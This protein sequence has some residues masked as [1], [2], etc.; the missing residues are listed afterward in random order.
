MYDYIPNRDEVIKK[1]KE[2]YFKLFQEASKTTIKRVWGSILE[3][4]K[5]SNEIE[6]NSI[7]KHRYI[8]NYSWSNITSWIKIFDN[9]LKAENKENII[10]SNLILP[11]NQE[12]YTECFSFL[13]E[14]LFGSYFRWWDFIPNNDN[15]KRYFRSKIKE[16]HSNINFLLENIHMKSAD[17]KRF[18]HE[19]LQYLKEELKKKEESKTWDYYV[20]FYSENAIDINV[21]RKYP[22][23]IA[24]SIN[25]TLAKIKTLI[26][27]NELSS[28]EKFLRQISF[29]HIF[30]FTVS[31]TKSFKDIYWDAVSIEKKYSNENKLHLAKYL[32]SKI[33]EGVK[34][35]LPLL[36]LR[37][38]GEEILRNKQSKGEDWITNINKKEEIEYRRILLYAYFL[39]CIKIPTFNPDSVFRVKLVCSIHQRRLQ[40][41][42]HF[43]VCPC[44][45][46][47]D[48]ETMTLLMERK[49]LR[50]NLV[51]IEK[52]KWFESSG[53]QGN[54]K[55]KYERKEEL[56]KA[57]AKTSYDNQ[58]WMDLELSWGIKKNQIEE[59]NQIL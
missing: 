21:L 20:G 26:K 13:A 45:Y 35:L 52:G 41:F 50:S 44:L 58:F 12:L 37:Y 14:H 54:L 24:Y 17:S 46:W 6:D 55:L 25:S 59:G 39:G 18:T 10:S 5:S 11:V 53:K 9:H 4:V 31:D 2:K 40:R 42:N 23:E 57:L 32:K 36:I 19:A 43:D 16:R 3:L 33:E 29:S 15:D 28:W 51:E 38:N 47:I 7:S 49:V 56:H 22:F 8:K 1:E 48:E 27:I 34:E 30:G